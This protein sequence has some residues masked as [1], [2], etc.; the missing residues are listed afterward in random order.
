MNQ[1][2]IYII[3]KNK[4]KDYPFVLFLFVI[5]IYTLTIYLIGDKLDTYGAVIYYINW[6]EEIAK[7]E[8]NRYAIIDSYILSNS[9]IAA[10]EPV[11]GLLILVITRFIKSPEYVL[12]FLNVLMLF[13]LTYFVK[14]TYKNKILIFLLILS[15]TTGFYEYVLLH[16]THRFKIAILFFMISLFYAGRK[17]KL[18]SFFYVMSLLS[19]LSMLPV[20][21]MIL[22]LKKLGFK[23]VPNISYFWIIFSFV[24][25]SFIHS[26]GFNNVNMQSP[27]FYLANKFEFSTLNRGLLP[28]LISLLPIIFIIVFLGYKLTKRILKKFKQNTVFWL[29]ILIGYLFITLFIVGTSRLLMVYYLTILVLIL[30]N[31]N[32]FTLR[33]RINV[34]IL[35]SPVFIYSLVNGFLKGPI[36]FFYDNFIN[37]G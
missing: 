22:F 11:P 20:I 14:N 15:I 3:N 30:S 29:G 31:W 16:M 17:N 8:F 28:R 10:P 35:F 26:L 5:I 21:P 12:H 9:E 37:L 1:R 23:Q 36:F 6:I 25:M 2:E 4:S 34:S 33:K 13:F 24:F 27:L 7:L 32:F 19:H 18:S